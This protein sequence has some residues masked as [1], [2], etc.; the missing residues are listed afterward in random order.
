MTNTTLMDDAYKDD[1][2]SQNTKFS[3]YNLQW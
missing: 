2:L 1:T 3:N